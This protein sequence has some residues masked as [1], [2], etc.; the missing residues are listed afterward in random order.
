MTGPDRFDPGLQP[1]RTALAWT[2]TVLALVVGSAAS[3]RLLPPVFGAWSIG[4]GVLGLVATTVLWIASARRARQVRH[5]LR[6]QGPLP[7]GTLLTALA[8]TAVT[9]AALC[10]AWAAV[11]LT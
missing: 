1:E 11:R 8:A 7:S 10:I 5:A 3:L 9:A 2:R 6:V 4:I